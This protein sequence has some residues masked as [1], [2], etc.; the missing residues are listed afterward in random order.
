MKHTFTP[1]IEGV[2][3]RHFGAASGELFEHSQLLQY[4]NIK[5][6]SAMRGSKSRSS[7][8]NL[9]ALY[10]LIEDYIGR[11]FPDAGDYQQ[12]EGA[13]FKNLFDRQRELP[14]G[15]KLQ[16]HALN[17]RLNE[18]FKKYFP[19]SEFV[20]IIRDVESR[21]Y[22]INQNLL[23]PTTGGKSYDLAAPVIDIIKAYIGSKRDAFESF[24]KTC[25][26]LTKI[27]Q[28]NPAQVRDFIAGLLAPNV[29]ARLFE[30]VGYSIL[31]YFYVEQK[32]YFGYSLDELVEE[33]LK[34]YKTGRTNAND[35]GIDYVMRPLG[36]F[37]QV[38]ETL[39]VKKYFLDIDKI[40]RFPIT[41]VIKSTEDTKDLRDRLATAARRQYAVAAVVDKYMACIEEIINIPI[42][43]ERFAEA[44]G[45]GHL[46][47][48]LGEIVLQSM[49]EFNYPEEQP[50]ESV[51]ELSEELPEE[52][53]E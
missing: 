38:T 53:D 16:N 7:F 12:Y 25:N 29:D 28:E 21:R 46:S 33:Q 6:R 23:R 52:D 41:F 2:L 32:V 31:K 48:I 34:L 42:L 1:V 51:E 35:G 15:S 13:V 24:I 49:V 22:W 3:E 30:I 17:H 9:Y 45:R 36:R 14:F 50:E 40:E 19:A 44:V 43:Q 39:D 27:N 10:V 8:A 37:F 11:G 18:E 5:T 47:S 4:I 26:E 20:P